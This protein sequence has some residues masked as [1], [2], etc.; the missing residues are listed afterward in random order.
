MHLIDSTTRHGPSLWK[1]LGLSSLWI[2]SSSYHLTQLL[3]PSWGKHRSDT[4]LP[5][6]TDSPTIV[7]FFKK[8]INSRRKY[9]A[10]NCIMRLENSLRIFT[11]SRYV[12]GKLL[13]TGC[14]P[15]GKGQNKQSTS[16]THKL[17]SCCECHTE[18]VLDHRHRCF[19]IKV[20]EKWM[21]LTV[22]YRDS[23]T[24]C[25]SGRSHPLQEYHLDLQLKQLIT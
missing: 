7:H 11:E 3:N 2:Y 1:V 18:N 6:H 25:C 19:S 17:S 10:M 9:C 16:E 15:R 12:A 8:Y 4:L 20:S 14:W 22:S 21:F 5:T 24:I 23:G 13:G